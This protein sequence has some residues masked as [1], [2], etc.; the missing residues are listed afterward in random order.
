VGLALSNNFLLQAAR[1][2]TRAAKRN[3][4][5]KL[6]NHLPNVDLVGNI[7]RN[8]SRSISSFDTNGFSFDESEI[9]NTRYSLQFSWPLMAGGLISS[10]RREAYA[11][12]EKAKQEETLANNA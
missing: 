3:A 5:S 12:L 1:L 7:T 8:T 10:E 4:Q 9:E 11:L 6:S 2:S